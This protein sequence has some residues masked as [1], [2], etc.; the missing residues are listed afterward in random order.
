MCSSPLSIGWRL[1]IASLAL[2]GAGCGSELKWQVVGP[3]DGQVPAVGPLR[4]EVAAV[5]TGELKEGHPFRWRGSETAGFMLFDLKITNTGDHDLLC[6]VGHLDFPGVVSPKLTLGQLLEG[7]MSARPSEEAPLIGPE[8]LTLTALPHEKA[9]ILMADGYRYQ[10]LSHYDFSERYYYLMQKEMSQARAL[11][12]IPHAGGFLAMAK[13]HDAAKQRA[14]RQML[15]EQMV[16][17]PGVVP[18]GQTVR[19]Y[20]VFAWPPD[21]QPGCLTLRLP[22][23][24]GHAASIQFS[25]VQRD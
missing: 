6:Q 20:L 1:V 16:M 21:P 13:M 19:G 22:V 17:R 8:D 10:I 24:P 12:F 4:M 2:C 5:D 11:A 7:A 15:A 23:Q 25:L 18:A 14:K 9:T 3:V